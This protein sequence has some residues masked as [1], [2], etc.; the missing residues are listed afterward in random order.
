MRDRH[1]RERHG[2]LALTNRSLV[3]T[4][5]PYDALVGVTLTIPVPGVPGNDTDVDGDPL[6]SPGV[7]STG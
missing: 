1:T 6:V 4:D 3:V 7:S 2:S 5:G